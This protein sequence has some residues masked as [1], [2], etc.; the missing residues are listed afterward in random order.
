MVLLFF[1][2]DFVRWQTIPWTS[3][4]SLASGTCRVLNWG[5]KARWRSQDA[6]HLGRWAKGLQQHLQHRGW[7][8]RYSPRTDGF[9]QQLIL[10]PGRTRL[11]VLMWWDPR[12]SATVGMSFMTP[13]L[14]MRIARLPLQQCV[15]WIFT[16]DLLR[17]GVLDFYQF[18]A[19]DIAS[20]VRKCH[21][22]ESGPPMHQPLP[23]THLL[24]ISKRWQIIIHWMLDA[25]FCASPGRFYWTRDPKEPKF[26]SPLLT[27]S[28]QRHHATCESS[29]SNHEHACWLRHVF[30]RIEEACM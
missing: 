25:C 2:H 1:E 18:S 27:S 16:T 7:W 15:G 3:L 12:G 24:V 20:L 14:V 8:V 13:A 23:T 30:Q 11:R 26:R 5:R 10:G 17:T 28:R 6:P 22:D 21:Y 4:G 29:M 19:A 9:I